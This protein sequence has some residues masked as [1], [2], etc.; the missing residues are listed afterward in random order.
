MS[1]RMITDRQCELLSCRHFSTTFDENFCFDSRM[2]LPSI[3]T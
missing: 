1:S 3:L 2:Y